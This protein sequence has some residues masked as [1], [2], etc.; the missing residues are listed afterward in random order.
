MSCNNGTGQ[1]KTL[2]LAYGAS[3][4]GSFSACIVAVFTVMCSNPPL[5]KLLTYRLALYQVLSCLTLGACE[6]LALLQ[7]FN[8]VSQIDL[9]CIVT[10]F[11]LEYC[12]WTKLLFVICLTFHLF[13]FAVLTK[14]LRKLEPFYIGISTLFPLVPACIPMATSSYGTAGAW[15]WI[16]DEKVS[17]NCT[18]EVYQTGLIE[19]YALWLGPVTFALALDNIAVVA[20]FVTLL[21]RACKRKRTHGDEHI[22]LLSH[23][24]RLDPNKEAFRQMLP[25]L[26]YPVIFFILNSMPLARRIYEVATHKN[27]FTLALL[28]AILGPSWGFFSSLALIVHV[29]LIHKCESKPRKPGNFDDAPPVITAG[30]TWQQSAPGGHVPSNAVTRYV[31]PRES[32]VDE[33]KLAKHVQLK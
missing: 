30:P 29:C 12:L 21:C 5:Y 16:P 25:L 4:F 20:I 10:G 3:G 2:L 13:C 22:H 27:S 23:S 31:I 24:Q 33:E 11:L 28:H 32:E 8:R 9:V 18:V 6:G 17:Q 14:N 26:A 1:T 15:C 7:L 19:Q